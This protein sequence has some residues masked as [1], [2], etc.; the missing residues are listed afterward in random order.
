MRKIILSAVALA[1]LAASPAAFAATT[2]KPAPKPV[3]AKP[4]DDVGTIASLDAKTYTVT[5]TDSST[6]G[7]TTF[8]VSKANWAK[9][10]V[11]TAFKTGDKVDVTYKVSG[12]T[13]WA[14]AIKVAP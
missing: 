1:F 13:D 4:L 8:K 14:S 12:K 6:A 3:A 7:K 9:W 5:L 2:P 11:A 10:K